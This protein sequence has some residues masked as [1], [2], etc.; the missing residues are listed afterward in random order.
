MQGLILKAGTASR[1]GREVLGDF[2][3]M[4]T[5]LLAEKG[6]RWGVFDVEHGVFPGGLQ[7]VDGVVITGSQA[8]ANDDLDW[9]NR[10]LDTVR[11]L[12]RLE[13]PLAGICFGAQVAA[14]A[15]GGA[16][17]VNPA[18]WEIGLVPV[19]PTAAAAALPALR[20][21]PRPLQV[22]QT[23]ADI[24]SRLPPGATLLA[25]SPTTPVE[26]F[27]LGP[28]VLGMQGHPEMDKREVEII[29]TKRPGLPPEVVRRGLSS[30]AGE[31]D[32]KFLAGL[33][34]RF[35]REGGL[36]AAAPAGRAVS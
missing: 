21:W 7:G 4:V 14:R 9:V 10:L 1:Y 18:G 3:G 31:P 12:Y 26:M 25:S 5:A 13:I 19:S 34:R 30:L 28:R 24:I 36:A 8:S 2:D 6:G 33:L 27:H 15:L 29:L 16:V 17:A 35:F 23:H 22:L 20:G 32:R 11:E